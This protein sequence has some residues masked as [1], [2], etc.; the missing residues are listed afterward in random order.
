M[1]RWVVRPW[2]VA[3]SDGFARAF[4][5][6]ICLGGRG[7]LPVGEVE[8]AG[9]GV[10]VPDVHRAAA[11]ERPGRRRL[12]HRGGGEHGRRLFPRR[13]RRA[14]RPGWRSGREAGV[15]LSQTLPA[16]MAGARRM[17]AAIRRPAAAGRAAAPRQRAGVAA[18]VAAAAG[19]V[20]SAAR[21]DRT[22][23][24]P[25]VTAS[26]QIRPAMSTQAT[27]SRSKQDRAGRPVGVAR[28]AAALCAAAGRIGVGRATAGAVGWA[29]G[30]GRR[31]W[32]RPGRAPWR[33]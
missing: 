22:R 17:S 27:I 28:L 3:A 26:A 8:R 14:D 31:R 11:R 7:R 25:Q 19:P 13:Q 12:G 29:A 4:C 24:R 5:S 33:R 2:I 30:G 6:A 9:R 10:R 18:W 15:A 23:R 1:L 20:A 21:A 16:T 32:R